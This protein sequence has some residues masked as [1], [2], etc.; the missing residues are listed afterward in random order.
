MRATDDGK[1][2]GRRYRDDPNL[3]I[4]KD[5]PISRYH[6]IARMIGS[7]IMNG[8][9]PA[10]SLIGTE[11][12][13]A[14]QFGV[15]RITIRQ[16]LDLLEGQDLIVRRRARGTFVADDVQPRAIVRLSGLLDDVLLQGDAA[17]TLLI[18]KVTMPASADVAAHLKVAEG[19]SIW[20]LRRLRVISA[21]PLIPKAWLINYLPS[22]VGDRYDEATLTG[23]SLLQ[24]LDS[25]PDTRL[26]SG[27]ES[28]RADEAEDETATRLQIDPGSPVLRVDR[29]VYAHTGE[30][31]EYLHQFY[32]PDRFSFRVHMERMAH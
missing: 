7:R 21:D 13:L 8:A 28:I 24:L 17:S 4:N 5:S 6:G 22:A 27:R 12:E 19:D 29:V 18:D 25:D 31:V 9:Y 16:A 3:H 1:R 2:S 23:A 26:A 10:G 30:P 11:N 32:R 15:S 14:R 20:R